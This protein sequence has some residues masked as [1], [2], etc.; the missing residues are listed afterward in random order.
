MARSVY[1]SGGALVDE[2]GVPI[3]LLPFQD[4]VADAIVSLDVPEDSE[5]VSAP[6]TAEFNAV[7]ELLRDL[8][9]AVTT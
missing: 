3:Q 6:T 2:Q 8:Q 4:T 9:T 1:E 7:L 5:E